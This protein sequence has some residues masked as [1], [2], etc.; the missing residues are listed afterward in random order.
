MSTSRFPT[1]S[2]IHVPTVAPT[3]SLEIKEFES[4]AQ[5][6]EDLIPDVKNKQERQLCREVMNC[7]RAAATRLLRRPW[8]EE[9]GQDI[10]EYAVMLA[11]ILVLVVGTIRLIGTNANNVFSSAASALQ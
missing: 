7:Y 9:R 11:V 5:L 1:H 6:L 10:A 3:Y 8:S 4:S 2:S